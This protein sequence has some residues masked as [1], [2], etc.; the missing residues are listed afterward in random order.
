MR[1]KRIVEKMI[2]YIEKV[3]NYCKGK[4]EK[5]FAQD[6]MLIEACVFNLAQIGELVV[7]LS[8]SFKEEN[9]HIPWYQIKG[10]R[11]KIVHD[12]QGISTVIVWEVIKNDL[13]I[14]KKDLEKA[15]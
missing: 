4:D 11:N 13:P 8:E 12:Y 9:S 14:L 2:L 10:L 3:E 7:S 6:N 15:L 1:D 5:I